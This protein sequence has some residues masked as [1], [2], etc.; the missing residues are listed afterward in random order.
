MCQWTSGSQAAH[1]EK[2]FPSVPNSGIE[3]PK[4][5]QE[6]WIQGKGWQNVI[7]FLVNYKA[8]EGD[9]TGFYYDRIKQCLTVHRV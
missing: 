4:D 1:E 7:L 3:G 2:Y 5:C 6:Q 9:L 8:R